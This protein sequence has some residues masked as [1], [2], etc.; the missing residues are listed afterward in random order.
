MALGRAHDVG[1]LNIPVDDLLGVEVVEGAEDAVGDDGDGSFVDAAP[2]FVDDGR[3]GELGVIVSVGDDVLERP[4]V[5]GGR[6]GERG[7]GN[8]RK[9]HRKGIR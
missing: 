2:V 3:S 6:D 7:R 4:G 8:E 5:G 9:G 1:R